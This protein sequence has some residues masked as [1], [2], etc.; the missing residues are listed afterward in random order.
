MSSQKSKSMKR[1]GV[2]KRAV[3]IGRLV[4]EEDPNLR[5]YYVG[6]EVYLDRALNI[7]DP[8]IFYMGPKGIGKS[9]VLQMIRLE[10]EHDIKRIINISPDDLAFSALVNLHPESPILADVTKGQ[11]LFKSLW[12]YILLMELWER[13]N[14]GTQDI[15]KNFMR[16]FR[17]KDER[18][19]R[20]LFNITITDKGN[21][22]TLTDRIIQLI[23]EVEISAKTESV[24][25]SGKVKIEHDVSS[26]FQLLSEINHAVK[27]LPVIL[28]NEYYVL[29]D[30]L[31]LYWENEPNQNAFI[32]ALFLSLRRL[33]RRPVKFIVSIREDIYRCL[34][35]TD[36]DKSRDRLQLMEWDLN[37]VREMLEKRILFALKCKPIDIWGNVFPINSF[38]MIAKH[39]TKKP[40]ELIR[41]VDLCLNRAVMNGHKRVFED[42]ISEALIEYSIERLGDLVS[43]YRFIYPNLDVVLQKFYGKQITLQS[44]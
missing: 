20:K 42:D 14:S 3:D 19:I 44:S 24:E 41:L 35:L 23:K 39:S 4:A 13:E 12:D 31:D 26:Q 6:R 34:P 16:L 21:P 30:D 40:R 18:R 32:A 5:S 25:V 17:S 7:D 29:I 15:L 36:K 38:D 22:L 11:W 37:S 43:E 9:A 1:K 28:R 27:T 8:I 33:S 2:L 10:K